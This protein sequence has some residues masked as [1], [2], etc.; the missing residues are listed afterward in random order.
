MTK[1][2]LSL[3]LAFTLTS[4]GA[5]QR[6]PLTSAKP[7][8]LWEVT[9]NGAR[10]TSYIFGTFHTFMS[11]FVD[12]MQPV[13]SRV[14]RSTAVV[15]EIVL[16]DPGVMMGVAGSMKSPV[17]L[18]KL[19]SEANYK[20]ADSVFR[21]AT[22]YGIGMFNSLKPMAAQAQ[23][24]KSMFDK[25][26]DTKS[27]SDEVILDMYFQNVAAKASK[28]IFGLETVEEQVKILFN[29]ITI[30]RQAEMLMESIR[31]FDTSKIILRTLADC[32]VNADMDCLERLGNESEGFSKE[33]MDALVKTRNSNW[34]NKLPKWLREHRLFIAVG[35]LHLPGEYGVVNLLRKAGYTVTPVPIR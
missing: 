2:L 1:L 24:V 11:G 20:K 4:C 6:V 12:T 15:G 29:D 18:K 21:W 22:G 3:L 5:T 17:P 19:L 34:M 16:T 10:D 35:A 33:E 31:E 30:E 32:Y 25:I 8:L 13:M 7:S 28:S 26:Y 27:D 9:G 23:L 14:A